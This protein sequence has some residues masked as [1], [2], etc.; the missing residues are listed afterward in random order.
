MESQ[1]TTQ[2]KLVPLHRFSVRE[3]LQWR[4]TIQNIT[5]TN[6]FWIDGG[7]FFV[8]ESRVINTDDGTIKFQSLSPEVKI[9][10]AWPG[11]IILYSNNFIF[12]Y[13]F[14]S[15]QAVRLPTTRT[16]Y[17][18]SKLHFGALSLVSENNMVSLLEKEQPDFSPALHQFRAVVAQQ[19]KRVLMAP[20]SEPKKKGKDD[21]LHTGSIT[22]DN[23]NQTLKYNAGRFTFHFQKDSQGKFRSQAQGIQ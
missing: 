9:I 10:R 15:N 8:F 17:L 11:T 4:T 20:P 23:I 1:G 16:Q 12:M 3:D 2:Q 19:S 13:D 21:G 14:N 7:K 18:L 5:S 6:G 22:F